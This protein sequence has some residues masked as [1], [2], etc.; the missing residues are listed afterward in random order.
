[1]RNPCGS[2][3][4]YADVGQKRRARELD[5]QAAQVR[6][7]AAVDQGWQ[8]SELD[9]G[10]PAAPVSRTAGGTAGAVAA[11]EPAVARQRELARGNEA[12]AMAALA[13]ALGNL[14]LRQFDAA[15]RREARKAHEE[16]VAI[17]RSY[18]TAGPSGNEAD[19]ARS[20]NNLAHSYW[21]DGQPRRALALAEESVS[22]LRPTADAHPD[23]GQILLQALSGLRIALIASDRR[24]EGQRVEDEIAAVAA[25]TRRLSH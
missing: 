23:C 14:G 11:A 22:I 5:R 8:R 19:L 9:A 4:R 18:A 15:R 13:R 12:A 25:E 21:A 1:M 24:P 17:L 10:A 16:A 6:A 20:L 2:W 7:E 3:A